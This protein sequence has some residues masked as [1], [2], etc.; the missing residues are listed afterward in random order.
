[1]STN[2]DM[3]THAGVY[4]GGWRQ[5]A[6]DTSLQRWRHTFTGQT[7]AHNR[8]EWN[9]E[10]NR[11]SG[12][13][14]CP[15]LFPRT[16]TAHRAW[17]HAVYFPAWRVTFYSSRRL[18]S[19]QNNGCKGLLRLVFRLEL[20]SWRICWMYFWHLAN[21]HCMFKAQ[22]TFCFA[23]PGQLLDKHLTFVLYDV[24]CC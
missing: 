24:L 11:L 7:S 2:V 5:R 19:Q 16:G 20:N 1:M 23:H 18:S 21:F 6:T 4:V 13:R 9:R 12:R 3:L 14:G 17:H 15:V 8:S 10:E 22:W